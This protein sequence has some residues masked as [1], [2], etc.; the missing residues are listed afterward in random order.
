MFVVFLVA[1]K[2]RFFSKIRNN[3]EVIIEVNFAEAMR[4]GVRFFESENGV[5]L[6]EGVNGIIPPH[7]LKKIN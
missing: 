7:C 4:A 5:I 1:S 2:K 3:S 6:S